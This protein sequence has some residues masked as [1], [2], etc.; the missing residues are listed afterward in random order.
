MNDNRRRLMTLVA[1]DLEGIEAKVSENLKP[2]LDLVKEVASHL[3][4]SG[5]KR[6]RP[7]LMVLGARLCGYNGD[8]DKKY[9]S[10]FEYIHAATLLHDDAVSYTHLRAHET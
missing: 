10:A 4:F 3:L 9:A 8:N 7:L 6:F 2:Y 5:G 1:E